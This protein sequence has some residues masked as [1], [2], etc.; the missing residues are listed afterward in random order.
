MRWL[1]LALLVL[2]TALAWTGG[3]MDWVVSVEKADSITWIPPLARFIATWCW[4][5]LGFVMLGI[6]F[7]L[8]VGFRRDYLPRYAPMVATVVALSGAML[9]LAA[10]KAAPAAAAAGHGIRAEFDTSWGYD[11][12]HFVDTNL[13]LTFAPWVE[14][15]GFLLAGAGGIVLF[16][17][18]MNIAR[19]NAAELE[20]INHAQQLVDGDLLPPAPPPQEPPIPKL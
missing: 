6:T 7:A 12:D 9:T 17:L 18:A 11:R 14:L 5:A 10:R 4:I 16:V 13:R 8:L 2:G 19:R 20:R 1:G 3:L 15:G